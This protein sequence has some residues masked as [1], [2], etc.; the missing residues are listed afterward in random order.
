MVIKLI[1]LQAIGK[2]DYDH[3]YDRHGELHDES[4]GTEHVESGYQRY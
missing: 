1:S 2:E 3:A 4:S